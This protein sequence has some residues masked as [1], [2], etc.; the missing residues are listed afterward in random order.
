MAGNTDA[1]LAKELPSSPHSGKSAN[2]QGLGQ[3]SGKNGRI[4]TK[5]EQSLP[6][7]TENVKRY[8]SS[9]EIRTT[10]VQVRQLRSIWE[11]R[12]QINNSKKIQ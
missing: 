1:N 4:S 5:T 11:Q 10:P 12:I 7:N 2:L 3:G 6:S 9:S 8:H